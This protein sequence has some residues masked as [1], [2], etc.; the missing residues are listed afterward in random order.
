VQKPTSVEQ[1]L[2]WVPADHRPLL[3]SLRA[4]IRSVAPGAEE[5]IS[6]GM[7]AF[8]LNGRFFVSYSDFKQHVSLFPATAY[9]REQLG[10]EVKPYFYGKGTFRFPADRPIPAEL[11][12]RIVSLLLQEKSAPTPP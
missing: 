9:V 2:S 8:R 11:V 7:P 3:N 12:A 6:Y 5:V 4:T 10:D 1:Y